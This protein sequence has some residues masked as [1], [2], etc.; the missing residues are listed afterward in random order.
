MSVSEQRPGVSGNGPWPGP[1][2]TSSPSSIRRGAGRRRLAD[3]ED[4]YGR[5]GPIEVQ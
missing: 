1:S 5:Y 3:R 2:K 4:R